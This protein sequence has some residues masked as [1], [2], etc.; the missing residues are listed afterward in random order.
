MKRFIMAFAGAALLLTACE[1][2]SFKSNNFPEYDGALEW[3]RITKNADWSNRYD[4]Q[5]VVFDNKLWVIGGYNPGKFSGD[6]YLED[7]WSSEDG[8][9]W[10]LITDNAAFLGRKGHQVVVFDDGNGEAMYLIGGFS[11]EEASGKRQYNNDV[12]RSTDGSNWTEIK[13]NDSTAVN[14]SIDW[15]ARSNHRCVV[16]NQG[17]QNYIYLIGGQ[18]MLDDRNTEYA[19]RYYNDVW[20]STNGVDWTRV[21]ASDYGIRSEFAAAVDENGT[22]YLQGGIHGTEF[23]TD[24]NSPHPLPD[25]QFIWKSNDGEN[26][27]SQND[28]TDTYNYLMFRA[29]HQMVYYADRMWLL[30]GKTV[31]NDHYEFTRPAHY[32]IYTVNKAG[33]I[34]IDSEGVPADARH[35]YQAVV[36]D[37]KI[38]LLGG[39]TSANGQSNDVWT[40]KF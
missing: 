16:A 7:V 27:T 20:Q 35:G 14:D 33:D 3:E 12:W 40:A 10:E 11:M 26:W 13:T 9:N 38:F 37:D 31:S 25:W 18:V 24:D 6:S 29:D 19:T 8:K 28:S 36:F 21:F 15:H 39:F 34:M 2:R 4:H 32:E 1:P 5:A 30:P 23:V 17:G 22:I